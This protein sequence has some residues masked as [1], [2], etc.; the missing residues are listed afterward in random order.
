MLKVNERGQLIENLNI[1]A[2]GVTEPDQIPDLTEISPE[3]E[4]RDTGLPIFPVLPYGSS[5]VVKDVT[6]DSVDFPKEFIL[7]EE[8]E[9]EIKEEN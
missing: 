5:S 1:S 4:A 8:E 6:S 7:E 9:E 2:E 3:D